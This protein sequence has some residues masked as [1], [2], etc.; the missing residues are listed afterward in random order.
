[1]LYNYALCTDLIV[2]V[3]ELVSSKSM[4]NFSDQQRSDEASQERQSKSASSNRLPSLAKKMSMRGVAI[5]DRDDD[6]NE[7]GGESEGSESWGSHTLP[8]MKKKQPILQKSGAKEFK[9]LVALINHSSKA[10]SGPDGNP[11]IAGVL[12]R[13]TAISKY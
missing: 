12:K 2:I 6:A 4:V 1:L 10:K 11:A 3:A 9:G 8:S 13:W 7:G 5:S